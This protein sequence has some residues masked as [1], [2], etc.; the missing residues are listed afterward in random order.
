MEF[1]YAAQFAIPSCPPVSSIILFYRALGT[2]VSKVRSVQMDSW[3]DAQ[4]ELMK[5]GGNRQCVNFLKEQGLRQQHSIAER[6]DCAAALWYHEILTARRDG[7]DEPTEPPNYTPTRRKEISK[8]G[9]GSRNNSSHHH[10]QQQQQQ[11][12]QTPRN[13][14]LDSFNASIQT[15]FNES[16]SSINTRNKSNHK[17]S[18][19]AGGAGAG[20][21]DS[22]ASSTLTTKSSTTTLTDSPA[23]P[24]GVKPINKNEVLLDKAMG[25][26]RMISTKIP[27]NN[28]G[29]V[30]RPT[31]PQ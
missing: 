25:L 3:S 29:D 11:P 20:A 13:A 8:E 5:C 14:L 30:P 28:G 17:S 2:H 16:N 21:A 22:P 4:L 15:F 9:L 24:L 26:L 19:S 23:S 7:R 10:H 1:M 18:P 6:Y 31:S 27:S 12:Q